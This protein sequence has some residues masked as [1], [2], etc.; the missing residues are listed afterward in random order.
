MS[1]P[2][3]CERV[4]SGDWSYC[5]AC[6]GGVDTGYECSKCGRDWLEYHQTGAALRQQLDTMTAERDLLLQENTNRR[7]TLG[8]LAHEMQ[9]QSKRLTTVTAER[10]AAE[11][12]S[13]AHLKMY[14]EASQQLAFARRDT[15]LDT[16][17]EVQRAYLGQAHTSPNMTEIVEAFVEFLR[18]EAKREAGN[19]SEFPKSSVVGR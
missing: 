14:T 13:V 17:N 12:R 9:Q 6:G 19:S 18:E 1:E 16:A 5:P 8:D 10:D 3:T 2:L 11:M 7:V 15:L 4:K